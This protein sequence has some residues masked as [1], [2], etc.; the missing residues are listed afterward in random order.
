MPAKQKPVENLIHLLQS[1]P[2]LKNALETSVQN[3]QQ[4]DIKT[5]EDF[6]AFLDRILTHIPVEKELMPSVREFYF[7]ISQSP[8]NMLKEDADFNNWINE[9]VEARGN[10][11]DTPESTETLETFMKNPEYNID[12]YIQGPG[13]WLSYNQFLARQL[14]PGKRPIA[15]RCD[16]SIIVSPA[17]SEYRGQWAITDNSTITAKGITY[18]VTELLNGSAYEHHFKAGIFTHSFLSITDYHR[19]HMPVAGVIKEIKKI[20]ARTWVNEVKKPDGPLENIDDVGFQFT[21]TRAYIIIDSPVGL[22]AVMPVGMGHIS[23]VNIT[24]EEG[25]TLM[26][27]DEFGYFAFGGSDIIMLFQRGSVAFTAKENTHYKYGEQIA[28]RIDNGQL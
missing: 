27:G 8:G 5:L 28:R 24:A 11:M 2:G 26:K 17:D 13:G 7:V 14:K 10:F 1:N 23:S 9:F 15:G 18:P 3:A 4:P 25:V 21:H 20:P 19:F 16:D 6:Y 22:V 12:D